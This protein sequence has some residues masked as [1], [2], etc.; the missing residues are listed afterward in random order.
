V[1]GVIRSIK[2]TFAVTNKTPPEILSLIPDYW[3][4]GDK[5]KTF[6]FYPRMPSLERNLHFAPLFVDSPGLQERR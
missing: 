1:L 3:E 2:N 5:D 4:D 6:Q